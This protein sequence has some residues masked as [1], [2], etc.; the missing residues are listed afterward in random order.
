MTLWDAIAGSGTTVTFDPGEVLVR[1]GDTGTYCYAIVEGEVVVTAVTKQGSTVVLRRQGPGSVIGDLAAL[2]GG[3][4]SATVIARSPVRAI[5]LSGTEFQSLM[6]A[7]PE[8]ALGELRRL[9]LQV[10]TLT[11]RIVVRGDELQS[12]VAQI[13]LAN[14][15]ESGDPAFRS[16]RQELADWVGATREAVSRALKELEREGLVRLGRGFVEVVDR[17]GLSALG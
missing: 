15:D 10:T 16:T 7:D 14:M 11:E 5:A 8:L 1:L 6:R 9:A 4:R 17:G 13:L 3:P 12:R 2:E